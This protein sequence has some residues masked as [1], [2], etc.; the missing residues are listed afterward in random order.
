MT[1]VRVNPES[2]RAYGADAQTGFDAI[3]TDLV[4]LVN[5]VTEVRYFGPN[6]VDFKTRAGQ[7]AADFANK[8]NAD[9]G[10]PDDP[11][12][13]ELFKFLDGLVAKGG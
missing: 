9:L 11:A 6:A 12:T 2:V 5:E 10:L 13:E 8:L 3:R 1:V 4:A 7:L